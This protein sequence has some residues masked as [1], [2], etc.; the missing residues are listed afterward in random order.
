MAGDIF[1]QDANLF[2]LL[3]KSRHPRFNDDV[4]DRFARYYSLVLKWNPRLHLTTL[5][6]PDQFLTR[7]IDEVVFASRYILDDVTSFWDLGSGLGVPGIPLKILRPDLEMVLVESNRKKA[8]FLEMA[9][10]ELA[11]DRSRIV[12]QRI[13]TLEPLPSG[14]L[15]TARAVEQM[16]KLLP[17]MLNLAGFSVQVLLFCS[18]SLSSS[19]EGAV[20]RLIPGSDD[21]YLADLKCST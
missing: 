12:C 15:L 21:R 17:Q 20:P 11:L 6:E 4:I 19:L 13:E 7:H 2:K 1:G 10:S 18:R 9:I 8:I 5:V 16:E 14:S 3:L